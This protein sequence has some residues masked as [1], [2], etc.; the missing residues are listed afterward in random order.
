MLTYI[1]SASGIVWIALSDTN[2]VIKDISDILK[3]RGLIQK[4]GKVI[5]EV[6]Q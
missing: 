6:V 4:I 3:A 5:V 1:F 2:D